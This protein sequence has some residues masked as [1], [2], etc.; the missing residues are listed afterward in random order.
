M[1]GHSH[2]PAAAG[3]AGHR[4]KLALVL[5]ITATALV[6]EVVG[7]AVSGSL[8]LLADAGHALTDAAG[9]TLAL[10]A[11][12]LAQRPATPQ[13]TWGYRRAEVLAAAA[14]AAV[15]LAVGVFVL[16]EGVRRLLD[17]PEVAS[18]AMLVF[19]VVGLVGNTVAIAVLASD[20]GT[21]LNM[22]AAF[23][24]VVNDA[25][26]SAAVLVAAGCIA[27]F[28]WQRA[29]AVASLLIGALILPR[30]WRLLRETVDVLLETTPKGLDLDD[31][32]AHI[33]DLPHVR[34]VHDLH[35]SQV[36]TDLPVLSAHVVVDDDCFHDG[37]APQI[38]DQLQQCV[39]SHHGV[40][41][42][43]STFQLEAAGHGEHEHHTHA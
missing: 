26:G 32:R 23:L 39:A 31:V 14:Q 16:V 38:L 3:G 11:A 5:G 1:G 42:E 28:G 43:H 34:D 10:V 35:A 8:A 33:L 13:R 7:A 30:T 19:G 40:S 4:R 22:R 18:T 21:N 2:A 37:H 15:L 20:R 29:D 12:V 41:V 27:L 17:P 25:L 9:L 24:E 6:V 36:A